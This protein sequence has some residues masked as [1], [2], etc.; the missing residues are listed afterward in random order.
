M[1]RVPIHVGALFGQLVVLQEVAPRLQKNG[2]PRRQVHCR[3][4]CGVVKEVD[5]EPLLYGLTRSCGCLRVAMLKERGECH[6]AT[7]VALPDRFWKKVDKNGPIPAH[8]PELGPC[9]LWLGTVDADGYGLWWKN[10][11]NRRVHISTYE[12]A[13]GP[14]PEGLQ[15]D[16]LCRVRR[17]CN[18]GHVEPVTCRANLLRGD[19]HAAR[20]ARK[21]HCPKGHE[22]T[23]QNT[24]VRSGKRHCKACSRAAHQ[25][26]RARNASSAA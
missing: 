2:R 16:H 25:R 3:C 22:Y 1:Q 23:T 13:H 12:S 10:R 14:V 18:D 6:A 24:Y 26:W 8:C 17:C 9:H 4:A 11:R 20:N 5:L 15:L 21:T 7:E 19:T